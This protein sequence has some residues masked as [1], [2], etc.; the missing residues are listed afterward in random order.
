VYPAWFA[1]AEMASRF[2][3]PEATS[4]TGAA[5]LARLRRDGYDWSERIRGVSTPTL[6]LH[7]QGDPLPLADSVTRSYIASAELVVIPASGHMP[8]WEAPQ[9][10][11][12]LVDAF[13]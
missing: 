6:V 4:A 2:A 8:F 1:D 3:P 11:F 12:A 10:F 5:V 9:R 7:G 13:L